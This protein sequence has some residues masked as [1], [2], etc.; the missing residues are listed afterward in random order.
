[1]K[2]L[3]R[4]PRT[5]K[6]ADKHYKDALR[7]AKK[8]GRKVSRIAEEVIMAYGNGAWTITFDV[9]PTELKTSNTKTK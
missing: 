9:T 1:M 5:Y 3:K 4:N 8:D 6:I 7:R 2:V